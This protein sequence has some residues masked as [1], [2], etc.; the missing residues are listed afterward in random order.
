MLEKSGAD[1]SRPED[2]DPA[3][4]LRT[5]EYHLSAV[6]AQA[7]LDL[8]LHRLT[9]LE[10]E[11]IVKDYSELLDFIADLLEILENPERLMQVIR[12]E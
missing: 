4:G 9:G 1:A 3:Y 2:L 6:Q 5:G 11:K 7:I 10:Q 12:E 8:R